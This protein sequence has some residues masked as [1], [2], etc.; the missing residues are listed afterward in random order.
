MLLRVVDLLLCLSACLLPICC[1]QEEACDG[2]SDTCRYADPDEVAEVVCDDDHPSCSEWARLGECEAN[3]AYMEVSCAKSCATCHMKDPATRCLVTK[4]Q[5]PAVLRGDMDLLFN[6]IVEEFQEFD[7]TVIS[8]SPWLVALDGF[9]SEEEALALQSGG[10]DADFAF[11]ASKGGTPLDELDTTTTMGRNS[12][13]AWCAQQ[14]CLNN[15][16]IDAVA[17]RMTHLTTAPK[18][19]FEFLQILRYRE[20]ERYGMHHDYLPDQLFKPCGPRV[21][22][23]S[24]YLND[25][26]EGGETHFRDLGVSVSPK[27]GRALVWPSVLVSD[28]TAPDMRTVH[29]AL[30]VKRGVKYVVNAWV[31]L[32]DFKGWHAK[33]CV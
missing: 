26:E 10:H 28:P 20:T 14:K 11:E 18:G 19:N 29:E 27:L 30:A 23:V 6:R 3:P 33:G 8:R 16:H 4:N 15:P 25:V 24:L 2:D 1:G 22:T 17:A 21:L 13:T 31:H 7:V 32:F 9:I 5:I 12:S